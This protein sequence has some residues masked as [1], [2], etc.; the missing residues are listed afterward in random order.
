MASITKQIFTV[1]DIRDFIE[2][3]MDECI[4]TPMSLSFVME[5]GEGKIIATPLPEKE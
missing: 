1:G 5:E 3:I 2:P 4:I